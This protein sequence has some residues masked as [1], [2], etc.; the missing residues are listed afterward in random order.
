MNEH[1][2][3]VVNTSEHKISSTNTH[4][5]DVTT[6]ISIKRNDSVEIKTI[7]ENTESDN[8]AIQYGRTLL[9][10]EN[11]AQFKYIRNEAQYLNTSVY[12]TDLDAISYELDLADEAS[13]LETINMETQRKANEK[14]KLILHDI[15]GISYDVCCKIITFLLFQPQ[16][17]EFKPLEH[18]IIYCAVLSMHNIIHYFIS[19]ILIDQTYQNYIAFIYLILCVSETF[20]IIYNIYTFTGYIGKTLQN[21]IILDNVIK[22][23]YQT[24]D[25]IS[26]SMHIFMTICL[27]LNNKYIPMIIYF[28]TYFIFLTF[29]FLPFYRNKSDSNRKYQCKDIKLV[30]CVII[31]II[32]VIFIPFIINIS[33]IIIALI[34]LY[35]AIIFYDYTVD[36]ETFFCDYWETVIVYLLVSIQ[37]VCF[38]AFSIQLIN[39]NYRNKIYVYGIIVFVVIDIC[40]IIF[41][42]GYYRLNYYAF[43]AKYIKYVS[44][45]RW[46]DSY[47]N[48]ARTFHLCLALS[49]NFFANIPILIL[50]LFYLFNTDINQ[51]VIAWYMCIGVQILRE[52]FEMV[53]ACIA[54]ADDDE[55]WLQTLL[56][57]LIIKIAFVIFIFGIVFMGI[58]TTAFT[59]VIAIVFFV[60]GSLSWFFICV[61][62][63]FHLVN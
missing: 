50:L 19:F 2:Y 59:L 58:A 13:L 25:V 51:Y 30:I 16:F 40:F 56:L 35:L 24:L 3:E 32:C 4:K 47:E 60:I 10:S 42:Y 22:K 36:G 52:M 45:D 57:S 20:I 39:S 34:M 5:N 61:F 28:L 62:C 55:T 9:D 38:T 1:T 46:F 21:Y 63:C 48:D 17:I 31:A 41:M 7:E 37:S 23:F 54:K 26:F 11:E 49:H 14:L 6:K 29:K 43:I 15:T 27:V 18:D 53:W 33:L 8:I 44:K 12:R